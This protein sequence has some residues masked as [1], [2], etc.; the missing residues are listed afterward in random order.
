MELWNLALLGDYFVS[1]W[2]LCFRI[3][4]YCSSCS[5]RMS[6]LKDF[7]F[8]EIKFRRIFYFKEGKMRKKSKQKNTTKHKNTKKQQKT[9]KPQKNKGQKNIKNAKITK[10]K[11]MK[12]KNFFRKN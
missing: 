2:S 12:N 8:R 4:S 11:T 6:L 7:L 9:T 1:F 3:L 5:L 10:N